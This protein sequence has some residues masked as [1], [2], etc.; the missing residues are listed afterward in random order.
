MSLKEKNDTSSKKRSVH[1]STTDKLKDVSGVVSLDHFVE[2]SRLDGWRVERFL[3]KKPNIIFLKG[4]LVLTCAVAGILFFC[5]YVATIRVS[6]QILGRSFNLSVVLTVLLVL[7]V[8]LVVV[9]FNNL[10]SLII[11]RR[12]NKMFLEFAKQI[13]E[14]GVAIVR[15]IDSS[16]NLEMGIR[17]FFI[18]HNAVST[19]KKYIEIMI[20]FV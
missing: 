19:D 13:E 17:L 8:L 6:I 1:R 16:G 11:K 10:F 9:F 12:H 18:N 5:V 20:P 3:K 7:I 4:V 14:K 2:M 15:T